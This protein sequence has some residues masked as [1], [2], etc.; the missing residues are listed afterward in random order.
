MSRAVGRVMKKVV[1]K[2]NH[3]SKLRTNIPAG[4]AMAGPPLGPMLGQVQPSTPPPPTATAPALR[5][6]SSNA[7]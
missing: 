7:D 1:D 5:G 3:A 6:S 2:V 4:S